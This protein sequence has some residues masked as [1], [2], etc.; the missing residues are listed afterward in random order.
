MK[1]TQYQ[2]IV[3]RRPLNRDGE[4]LIEDIGCRD[5]QKARNLSSKA[6]IMPDEATYSVEKSELLS[7]ISETAMS[8]VAALAPAPS[9]SRVL[10]REKS[11]T[12]M[13]ASSPVSNY[14][15]ASIVE[16]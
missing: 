2:H 14:D 10:I 7:H 16:S 9:E 3:E 8:C 1:E 13:A 6:P 15:P 5:A 12:W 4:S 11:N